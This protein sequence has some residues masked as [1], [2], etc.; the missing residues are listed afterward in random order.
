MSH[1]NNLLAANEAWVDDSGTLNPAPT[2]AVSVRERDERDTALGCRQRAHADLNSALAMATANGRQVFEKSAAAWTKRA[3][4]LQRIE[5][6]IEARLHAPRP[7]PD[8]DRVELT[9]AEVAEDAA[10]L[11]L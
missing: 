8:G 7:T 1:S 5:T 10:Y 9:A 2:P 3:D 6:G 11:R 4:M